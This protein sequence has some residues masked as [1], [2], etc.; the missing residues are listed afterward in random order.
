MA[1]SFA[2]KMWMVFL[3]ERVL[4]IRDQR[5]ILRNRMD[6]PREFIDGKGEIDDGRSSSAEEPLG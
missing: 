2:T 3:L 4:S 5:S 6:G 1:W